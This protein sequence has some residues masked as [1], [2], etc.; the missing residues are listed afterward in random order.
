M[1]VA[2]ACALTTAPTTT[3]TL[4]HVHVRSHDHVCAF[5]RTRSQV[6]ND[7]LFVC[8][9]ALLHHDLRHSRSAMM[10]EVRVLHAAEKLEEAGFS[11]T[12]RNLRLAPTRQVSLVGDL[13]LKVGSARQALEEVSV[14]PVATTPTATVLPIVHILGSLR[15]ARCYSL[16][17]FSPSAV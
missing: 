13:Q 16:S 17:V 1:V 2:S 3:L 5:I 7:C 9:C 15:G 10:Q 4:L 6:W 8:F 11:E 12:A 14:T